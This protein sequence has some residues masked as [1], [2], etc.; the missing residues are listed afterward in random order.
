MKNKMNKLIALVLFILLCSAVSSYSDSAFEG[1]TLHHFYVQVGGGPVRYFDKNFTSYE[2][3]RQTMGG[4]V[5][6]L[7]QPEFYLGLGI[8]TGYVH[9]YTLKQDFLDTEFGTTNINNSMNAVPIIVQFN[10]R[11]LPFFNA[12]IG[13]GYFSAI[14]KFE[15]FG[16]TSTHT[17]MTPGFMAGANF[18]FPISDDFF[19]GPELKYYHLVEFKDNAL[20]L[21][22]ILS[23][24][25]FKW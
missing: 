18:F 22:L 19:I 25:L 2:M 11:L 17:Q 16:N 4:T 23:Y 5:R 6:V 10:M 24:D 13:T 7:W 3:I 14:S 8:E 1:D 20:S 12:Y 21:Q 9:F 15:S